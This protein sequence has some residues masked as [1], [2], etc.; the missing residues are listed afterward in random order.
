MGLFTKSRNNTLYQR[1]ENWFLGAKLIA[2]GKILFLGK[3]CRGEDSD[4]QRHFLSKKKNLGESQKLQLYG[5]F[6]FEREIKTICTLWLNIQLIVISRKLLKL[7]HTFLSL[8]LYH[9]IPTINDPLKEAFWK[10]C[11][12]RRKC[13]WPAFSPFPTMFSTLLKTKFNI[14]LHYLV[15]ANDFNLDQTQVIAFGK[16]LNNSEEEGFWKQQS[17]LLMTLWRR[18]FENNV[19]KGENAGHQ[20]FLLFPHWFLYN[21]RR[22]S[23]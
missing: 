10:Q 13:W 11:G 23:F 2:W 22:K 4:I 14:R 7:Y 6:L 12:K 17:R 9:T 21:Q 20:H 16:E 3:I 19:G 8:T 5:S 1:R 15:A 18:P